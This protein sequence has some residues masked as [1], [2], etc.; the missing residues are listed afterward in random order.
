LCTPNRVRLSSKRTA[1]ALVATAL[2]LTGCSFYTPT[3]TGN[4]RGGMI[5]GDAILDLGDSQVFKLAAE[6]C[7]KYRRKAQIKSIQR[8]A[9]YRAALFDCTW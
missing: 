1:H 5:A 3:V 4:W 8:G 6:H 7:A 2:L 9:A